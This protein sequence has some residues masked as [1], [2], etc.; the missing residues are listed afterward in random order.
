MIIIYPPGRLGGAANSWYTH[1]SMVPTHS[2]LRRSLGQGPGPRRTWG[3]R[4]LQGNI[5]M[6]S[7]TCRCALETRHQGTPFLNLSRRRH[8]WMET[9]RVPKFRSEERGETKQQTASA[10]VSSMSLH[11][12]T[13]YFLELPRQCVETLIICAQICVYFRALNFSFIV[14]ILRSCQFTLALLLSTYIVIL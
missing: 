13:F 10:F 6:P 4:T 11:P 5:S 8:N 14:R 12:L 2:R 1:K 7:C 3:I 9:Q